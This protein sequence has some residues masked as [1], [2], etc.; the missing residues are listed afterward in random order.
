M[1]FT[2]PQITHNFQ[3]GGGQ[4]ATGTV[5]FSLLGSMNNGTAS[6]I[7]PA[8]VS[9]NLDSSGD[10]TTSAVP[11]NLDSGTEPAPPWNSLTRVD[12]QITGAQALSY[13]TAIPPIQTETNGGIVSGALSTLQLSSL[14]AKQFMVGQSVQ[15]AGNIP[16]G[17]TVISV[18][19][20]N[21]TA[22]MSTAGTAGSGLTA[23]LGANLDLAVLLPTTPQPL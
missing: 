5:E 6:I 23:T 7:E 17:A 11:S 15:C 20:T 1:S 21:N 9:V 19:T 10:M 2:Y 22:S 12:I 8:I 16:A 14:T 18:N 13:V 4:P 3:I